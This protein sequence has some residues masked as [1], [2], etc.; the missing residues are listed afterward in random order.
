VA[1]KPVE[2]MLVRTLS[3]RSDPRKKRKKDEKEIG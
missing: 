3:K 1:R 2:G